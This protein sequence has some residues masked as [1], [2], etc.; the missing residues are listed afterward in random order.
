[1]TN[2]TLMKAYGK[3][4]FRK[5]YC[6]VFK[7]GNCGFKI[8]R[9]QDNIALLDIFHMGE[10]ADWYVQTGKDIHTRQEIDV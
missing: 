8:A 6:V 2:N 5:N 7:R 9:Q 4:F 1:M 10:L 3:S